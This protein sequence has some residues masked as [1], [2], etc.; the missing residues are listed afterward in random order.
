MSDQPHAVIYA[1]KSTEDKHGSI[2]TQ[3]E[4][5]RRLA[6]H[7]G[8]A[9]VDPP[10]KDEN[11]SAF[12]GNRGQGLEDALA[13]AERLTAQYG[14][15]ALIVQH[16]DRLARG[17]GDRSRHLVEL[18]L[19]ARQ[20]GVRLMSVQDPQTFDGMGLVYAA[21]M[22]DRN[23]EDSARKSA[24][25][26]DG[27]RR[28]AE[29]G[30]HLGGK[31]PDGYRRNGRGGPIVLDPA[32][33]PVI[34]TIFKLAAEG[35]PDAHIARQLNIDGIR[36]RNGNPWN[37]RAVQD[38][39]L[40]AFYAKRVV[41]EGEVFAGK[42]EPLIEPGDYDRL[43]EARGERDRGRGKHTVGR[44]AKRHALKGLAVCGQCGRT[45]YCRTSSYRRV[46]G[47]R[48]R[49]Y[50]CPGYVES[51]GTC[52]A[53]P[54]DTPT[55]DGA[56]L[57]SLDRLIPDFDRWIEQI[58]QRQEGECTRLEQQR[59]RCFAD[60]HEQ[61]R[62][63]DAV[64]AKWTEYVAEGAQHNADLALPMVERQRRLLEQ[65][66]RRAQAAQDAVDSIPTET[67]ADALL[68]FA[69]A[70]QKAL[71][72]LDKNE[73]MAEVNAELAATFQ[74]FEIDRSLE[75]DSIMIAPILRLSVAKSLIGQALMGKLPGSASD[76]EPVWA[77]EVKRGQPVGGWLPWLIDEDAGSPP[78]EWLTAASRNE[79]HSHE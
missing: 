52:D 27:K 16:S 56:V 37:R 59:D 30:E 74:G 49:V 29:G 57:G 28:Q 79:R 15:C 62:K 53:L 24:A 42:H 50:A 35:V 70:L 17:D 65:V 72:G 6:D 44:P 75:D 77:S 26:K 73:A 2:K 60:R 32:R 39:I 12:K 46:D 48:Q 13:G 51:E 18:V 58:K 11:R 3:H 69:A 8:M 20:V 55:V 66:E 63:T 43:I 1:A 10:F 5:A 9:V 67:P 68:D 61:A 22:G 38:T 4:D 36:T 54:F 14:S 7:E 23:H 40:R 41:Y 45:M 47:S 64:E 34:R 25:V 76:S 33:A 31:A 71:K 78:M 19:W 21:L